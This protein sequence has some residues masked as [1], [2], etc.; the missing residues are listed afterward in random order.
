M[1]LTV[2]ALGLLGVS[3]LALMANRYRHLATGARDGAGPSVEEPAGQTALAAADLVDRFIAARRELSALIE[4]PADAGRAETDPARTARIRAREGEILERAGISE[5]QYEVLL[6]AW[7]DWIATGRQP[8][9][10]LGAAF[11]SRAAELRALD[12]GMPEPPRPP[13]RGAGVVN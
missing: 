8:P 4:P 7:R 3:A 2:G 9:G 11:E 5:R 1:L 12:R 13:S 6:G 10:A